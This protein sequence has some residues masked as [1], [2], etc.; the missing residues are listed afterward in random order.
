MISKTQN[1]DEITKKRKKP[2]NLN[3]KITKKSQRTSTHVRVPLSGR[4]SS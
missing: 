1:V 4:L 2:L 3:G